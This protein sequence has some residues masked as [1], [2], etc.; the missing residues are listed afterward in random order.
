MNN[1][2]KDKK[3]KRVAIIANTN[4]K[5]HLIEWAFNNREVLSQQEIFANGKTALVLEGTLNTPVTELA[6]RTLGGYR[7][8]TKL[9]SRGLMDVL[10]ILNADKISEKRQKQISELLHIAMEQNI[11]VAVNQATADIVIS[12]LAA[13]AAGSGDNASRLSAVV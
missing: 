12:T 9:I 3:A 10:I 13:E 5:T 2:N 4:H 1:T 7:D 6:S 11:V 8:L